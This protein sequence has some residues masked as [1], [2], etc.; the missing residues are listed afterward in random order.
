MPV[1]PYKAQSPF[2]AERKWYESEQDII[3]DIV[4]LVNHPKH[5]KFGVG[6][7]LYFNVPLF[8]DY[9]RICKEW[10]R[11]MISDY[12]LIKNFNVPLGQDLDSLNAWQS[13]CFILIENEL[14][15][16]KLFQQTKNA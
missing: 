9:Q 5:E 6:Q 13:D 4:K 15:N 10:H 2:S 7:T 1:L 14:T 16:V 12:Y 11:E 3:D 8:C